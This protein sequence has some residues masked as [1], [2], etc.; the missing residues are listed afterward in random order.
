MPELKRELQLTAPSGI[1]CSDLLGHVIS[2][3]Q[4]FAELGLVGQ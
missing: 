3:P 2:S 4:S 1:G